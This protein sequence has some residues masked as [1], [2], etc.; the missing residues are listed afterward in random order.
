MVPAREMSSYQCLI[1]ERTMENWNSAWVPVYRL[2]L[3]PLEPAVST[4]F[5]AAE[6]KPGFRSY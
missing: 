3:W 5:K 2:I 1:C 4:S 6:I